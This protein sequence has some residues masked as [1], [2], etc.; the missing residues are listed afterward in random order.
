[1]GLDGKFFILNSQGKVSYSYDSEAMNASVVSS[2]DYNNDGKEDFGFGLSNGRIY[3]ISP[4]GGVI[5]SYSVP[6]RV[7]SNILAV[8][9]NE[10]SKKEVIFSGDDGHLYSMKNGNFTNQLL[11]KT[12]DGTLTTLLRYGDSTDNN[13]PQIVY[14]I[15]DKAQRENIIRID[16]SKK[17]EIVKKLGF[18]CK[19]NILFGD[20]DGDGKLDLVVGDTN[21]QLHF[22]KDMKEEEKGYPRYLVQLKNFDGKLG[23]MDV[24][25][26]G[27][28]DI[29]F[30][31][32]GY[33]DKR[34][35]GRLVAYS[36]INGMVN[37]YP[38]EIGK[39]SGEFTI[40]DLN[41]DGKLETIVTNFKRDKY[42][43][44]KTYPK[45]INTNARIPMK[46]IIL[47]KELEFQ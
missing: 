1:L 31:S 18:K 25:N 40:G 17:Y 4:N 35:F 19:T 43:L 2:G 45:I 10:D 20:F 9:W 13:S 23:K 38:K 33:K 39:N 47:G 34:P 28:P 36:L 41:G 7:S 16:S 12:P 3:M 46:I 37:G 24:D 30:L 11:P 44:W 26:D 22:L 29:L 32:N 5:S 21:N 8:D 42:G 27:N 15:K 6:S 14:A